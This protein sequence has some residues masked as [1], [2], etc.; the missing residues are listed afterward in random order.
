MYTKIIYLFSS[1]IGGKEL[2][3]S[4]KG[5]HAAVEL[6]VKVQTD[7]CWATE[8]CKHNVL[9][10]WQKLYEVIHLSTYVTDGRF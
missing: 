5:G 2:L 6:I 1:L 9:K 10:H 3:T 4:Y 8:K 7:R